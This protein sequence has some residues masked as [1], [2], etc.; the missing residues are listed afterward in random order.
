MSRRITQDF[1]DMQENLPLRLGRLISSIERQR[2]DGL[3][4]TGTARHHARR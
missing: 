4:N 2:R 1:C 3:V